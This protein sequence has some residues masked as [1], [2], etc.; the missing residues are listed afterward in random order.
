MFTIIINVI[1]HLMYSI[2]NTLNKLIILIKDRDIVV[3]IDLKTKFE[4]VLQECNA[5]SDF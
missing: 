5:L 2:Q 3:T 1:S 4:L